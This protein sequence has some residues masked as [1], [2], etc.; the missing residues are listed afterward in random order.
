MTRARV[1]WHHPSEHTEH[2]MNISLAR[3]YSE[4]ELREHLVLLCG[5]DGEIEIESMEEG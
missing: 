3:S 4:E 1:L 2:Q 5:N